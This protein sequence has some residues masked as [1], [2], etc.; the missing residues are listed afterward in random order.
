MRSACNRARGSTSFRSTRWSSRLPS[1]AMLMVAVAAVNSAAA[2]YAIT[3]EQLRAGG[4]TRATARGDA[5]VQRP[6]TGASRARRGSPARRRPA[7]LRR[8]ARAARRR[9]TRRS[10]AP[11]PRS[12]APR[13]D[14]CRV[15]ARSSS[16]T[17]GVSAGVRRAA[18]AAAASRGTA[19]P[20]DA[21][22]PAA[23]ATTPLRARC[24]RAVRPS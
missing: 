19:L 11:P 10:P 8:T 9:A 16:I 1:P 12:R 18:V 7:A 23:R 21:S 22:S 14:R 2:A 13:R 6:S 24:A 4:R 20:C 5:R 3:A 17:P 15:L